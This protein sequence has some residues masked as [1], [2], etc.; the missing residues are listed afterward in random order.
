MRIVRW[1]NERQAGALLLQCRRI[2]SDGISRT[3][4]RAATV[5]TK[6]QWLRPASRW[7]IRATDRRADAMDVQTNFKSIRVERVSQTYWRIVLDKP[8]LGLMDASLVL[9]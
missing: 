6:V 4:Q 1:V 5:H 7:K 9:E 2:E 3:P 8:P